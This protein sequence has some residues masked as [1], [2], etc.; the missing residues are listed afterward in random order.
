MSADCPTAAAACFSG[1]DRGP[2]RQRRGAPCRWRWRPRSRARPRARPGTHG[3]DVGGERARCARRSGPSPGAVIEAAADLHHERA[4]RGLSCAT[5]SPSARSQPPRRSRA[6]ELGAGPPR[7]RG[8]G[9][10]GQPRAPRRSARR[11]ARAARRCRGEIDLVRGHDLRAARPAPPST[12]PAP[13]GS[14]AS[15]PPDRGPWRDRGR[16]GARAA[17]VRSVWRRKRMPE[18]L[19][20]RRAGDEPGQVGDDEAPLLVH[21]ARCPSVGTSVVNG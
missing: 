2:R 4:G 19:A 7:H 9:V 3:G 16:A 8:D 10:K 15:P 21:A 13:P 12:R 11:A 5:R 1:I 18:P 6:H 20:L 14:P 17:R